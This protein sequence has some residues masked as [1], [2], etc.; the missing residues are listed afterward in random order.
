M[1]TYSGRRQIGGHESNL[2]IVMFKLVENFTV[3]VAMARQCMVFDCEYAAYKL[4]I[5]FNKIG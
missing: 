1:G 5:L 3:L 2:H 4:T